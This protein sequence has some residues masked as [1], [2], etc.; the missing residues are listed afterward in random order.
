M[1]QFK[2]FTHKGKIRS[3]NEDALLVR[4]D[5][6][7]QAGLFVVADGMGGHDYGQYAS[8]QVCL[9]LDHWWQST[10]IINQTSSYPEVFTEMKTI[11]EGINHD[12]YDFSKKKHTRT[13]TTVSLLLVLGKNYYV[14]HIGDSRIYHL[15]N[16]GL[17]LLTQDDSKA[18]QDYVD[19]FI[20]KNAYLENQES[21]LLKGIGLT[22]VVFPQFYHGTV[23]VN[24][25]I[26]LCSD[27]LYQ[28]LSPKRLKKGLKGARKN[29]DK[30][31]SKFGN[32]A[33]SMGASDNLTGIIIR[34]DRYE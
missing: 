28:Y 33:L 26:M 23:R 10:S 27:G 19:G 13:G 31:L 32:Q 21:G 8:Q 25:I 30:S 29:M 15:V 4:Y 5:G 16:D 9:A 11:I 1:Y 24:D 6:N 3:Q 14:A 34:R 18:Y 17:K 20:D 2:Y 12:I 22:P 7:K